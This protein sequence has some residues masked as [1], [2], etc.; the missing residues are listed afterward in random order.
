MLRRTLTT[1]SQSAAATSPKPFGRWFAGLDQL[2]E[3]G[4]VVVDCSGPPAYE[5]AVRAL[6]DTL[7]CS[8]GRGQPLRLRVRLP[9]SGAPGR[10][11]RRSAFQLP[12]ACPPCFNHRQSR[13][14]AAPLPPPTARHCPEHHADHVSQHL[15]GA[16]C[17]SVPPTFKQAGSEPRQLGAL[18]RS[19]D[20][21]DSPAPFPLPGRA[22]QP[23]ARRG[24]GQACGKA[25][26]SAIARAA[27]RAP[28]TCIS[29]SPRGLLAMTQPTP[30]PRKPRSRRALRSSA[31]GRT[32]RSLPTMTWAASLRP[33]FGG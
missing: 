28:A 25:A 33:A 30:S 9:S 13:E 31:S 24:R 1:L 26:P 8:S 6:H 4:T 14:P 5:R 20:R 11:G 15:A 16:R 29:V 21:L 22:E 23:L 12:D 18:G 17:L 3:P 7:R 27:A 10:G 2:T 32:P 19:D